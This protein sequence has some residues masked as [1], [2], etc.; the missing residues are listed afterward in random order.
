M[1]TAE[2]SPASFEITE[3]LFTVGDVRTVIE[4]QFNAA[5][6]G[7]RRVV[8]ARPVLALC[9]AALAGFVVGRLLA[10]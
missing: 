2:R 5:D 3:P 6:A 9:A 10:R 1:R 7:L 4:A 8:G